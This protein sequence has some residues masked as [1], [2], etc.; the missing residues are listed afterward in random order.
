MRHRLLLGFL[1]LVFLL[2]PAQ[3]GQW[4][5][6]ERD[7]LYFAIN[8]PGDTLPPEFLS[9]PPAPQFLAVHTWPSATSHEVVRFVAYDLANDGTTDDQLIALMRNRLLSSGAIGE[10]CVLDSDQPAWLS[11]YP[12]RVLAYHDSQ[13]QYRTRIFVVRP[14]EK[15]FTTCVITYPSQPFSA[16]ALA[17]EDSLRLT[18]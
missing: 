13:W 7:D 17:F 15:L 8:F 1:L 11:G 6:L 14:Y 16:D 3:S 12:G 5:T 4:T 2:A 10:P 9:R 18:Q